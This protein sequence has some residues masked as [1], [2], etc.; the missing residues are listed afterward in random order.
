[1]NGAGEL[2]CP[3][4]EG[5][6]SGVPLSCAPCGLTFASWLEVGPSFEHAPEHAKI[7]LKLGL[8]LPVSS[9]DEL[10]RMLEKTAVKA[11]A[12]QGHAMLV[13]HRDTLGGSNIPARLVLSPRPA[14][15]ASAARADSGSGSGL[16]WAVLGL[17]A[18]GLGLG[19]HVIAG[20][21]GGGT[22]DETQRA[23]RETIDPS[24]ITASIVSIRTEGSLGTG[25]TIAP[26]VFLTNRHVVE[27]ALHRR[28]QPTLIFSDGRT[29]S[30]DIETVSD[31]TDLAVLVCKETTCKEAPALPMRSP[32]EMKTGETVFAFGSPVGLELSLS[33]GILSHRSRKVM[34]TLYLQTDLAVNPGNSG[35][36]LLDASG[37]VVGVVTLKLRGVEGIAFALPI[38]YYVDVVQDPEIRNRILED[39]AVSAFRSEFVAMRDAASDLADAK[40]PTREEPPPE[41]AKPP[42]PPSLKVVRTAEPAA[43]EAGTPR[44]PLAQLSYE[45]G[46]TKLTL[47]IELDLPPGEDIGKSVRLEL[48]RDDGARFPIGTTSPSVR[49]VTDG[50][51]HYRF[52]V[53]TSEPANANMGARG[54]FRVRV[55]DDYLS[56]SFTVTRR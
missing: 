22:E 13:R 46:R 27:D 47:K 11:G 34:G 9:L 41:P 51:I 16:R 54:K 18:A 23:P 35:G 25:F 3:R 37:R 26:G 36:P 19:F 5:S 55:G 45:R 31:R 48:E 8:K 28:A 52:D 33:R 39:Y 1:M 4:C 6:V 53:E 24:A 29:A 44:V 30:A 40:P 20:Q 10:A 38:D 2:I 50:A 42:P 14:R 32:T 15:G 17:A 21:R 43:P 49:R 12:G 7:L 56:D